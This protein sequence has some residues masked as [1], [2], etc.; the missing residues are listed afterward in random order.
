[1]DPN[2]VPLISEIPKQG[3]SGQLNTGTE[4]LR[5]MYCLQDHDG[6]NRISRILTL[7]IGNTMLGIQVWTSSLDN[8]LARGNVAP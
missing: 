5:P 8:D 3:L 4:L 1:M 2:K 7:T 6:L